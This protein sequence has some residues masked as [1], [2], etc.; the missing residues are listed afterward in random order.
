MKNVIF[1]VFKEFCKNNLYTSVFFNAYISI[2]R[3]TFLQ[4]KY[5]Y[6]PFGILHALPN[7]NYANLDGKNSSFISFS[8]L[9]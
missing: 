2:H 7:S 4:S 1:L 6:S 9:A 5:Y 3:R 8:K